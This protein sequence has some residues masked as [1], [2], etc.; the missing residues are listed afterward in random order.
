MKIAIDAADTGKQFRVLN[1]WPALI[2]KWAHDGKSLY[3]R[4]RQVG[5]IPEF[6]VQRVD[7]A[8]GRI[9][10]LLSTAPELILDLTYSPDDQKV[11]VIR[12]R[13]SSN[14]VML[15]PVAAK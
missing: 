3:Y 14:A 4:E 13:S 9:S 10:H 5:Y 7:I 8:T 2:M 15:T 11:A 1:S 12:G 6:E